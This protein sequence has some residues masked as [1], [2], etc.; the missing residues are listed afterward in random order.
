MKEAVQF[1]SDELGDYPYSSL[2]IV[3]GPLADI[4]SMEYPGLCLLKPKGTMIESK[5]L[6]AHEIV[7]NW[8]YGAL[9]TNER[10]YPW[11]DEGMTSFYT[12]RFRAS[13]RHSKALTEK[14]LFITSAIERTDQPIS[15]SSEKLSRLNYELTAYYKA[16]EWMRYL[17]SAMGID[18]FKKAMQAYYV[19]WQFKHPK[20]Q[21]FQTIIEQSSGQKLD[22][23]FALLNKKGVLPNQQRSGTAVTTLLTPE[24]FENTTV[25]A[26]LNKQSVIT[27]GPAIGFNSYDKLMLGASITNLRQTP[28]K[29]QFLLAPMW[30]IGSKKFTGIGF[31]NYSFYTNGLFRKIDLGVSGSTFSDNEFKKEDG[32]NA[33]FGFQKFVPGIRFTFKEKDPRST[34]HRYIQWKTFFLNEEAYRVRYDSL[35][36]PTDTT[37][38]QVVSTLN[39]RRTL[40]QLK[41]VVE[42]YR[43]LYPY[44]GELKI[45]QADDFVRAAFTGKYFFNYSKEGGL[46][47]RFFAGKFFYTSPKTITKQFSTDRYHLNLTGANGYEDYTYSDYFLGRNKFEGIGSQQIMVRDGGFKVRTDLLGDKVGRTDN[48]LVAVNFS[49]TIPSDINP[50]S[51]LPIPIPLKVFVDVGT[52]A[53]GWQRNSGEDRFVFD[54]GI[55][56]PVLKETINIYIPLLYSKVFKDYKLSYLPKKNRFLKMISFSIDISNFTPRKFNRNLSF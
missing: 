4:V 1:F 26:L 37:L 51:L 41:I 19:N 14:E 40:N 33:Y 6:L 16:A 22:T 32:K 30:G 46:D 35:I 43:A 34:F 17:E 39:E 53:D 55:H 52:N 27:I 18:A 12:D 2:N 11:M 56:I 50:L 23:V 8:F 13:N 25:N 10:A 3:Q 9:A 45:E 54:A 20:P 7:H 38:K 28:S 29:L 24:A 47:V 15:T 48:W 44:R 31:V 42:N 21:D 36:T 5:Y 49:S